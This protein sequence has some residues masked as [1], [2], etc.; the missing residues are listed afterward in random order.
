MVNRRM[1]RNG[2]QHHNRIL[3][4]LQTLLRETEGIETIEETEGEQEVKIGRERDLDYLVEVLVHQ[5]HHGSS[6]DLRIRPPQKII[7]KDSIPNRITTSHNNR[8]AGG[9]TRS[10]AQV[11]IVEAFNILSQHHLL[12]LV[13]LEN[14][15]TTRDPGILLLPLRRISILVL[16]SMRLLNRMIGEKNPPTNSASHRNS[17]SSPGTII[18]KM[19]E[20]M[21][22]ATTKD[23]VRLIW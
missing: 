17:H 6:G 2:L 18:N 22:T 23:V 13:K 3:T 16:M 1:V 10:Q 15:R 5:H 11:E 4:G 8:V 12:I 14:S 7:T 19:M 21:V 9:A 20:D